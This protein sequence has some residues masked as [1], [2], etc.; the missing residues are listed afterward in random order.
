[1]YITA[2]R[3]LLFAIS[4]IGFVTYIHRKTNIQVEFI[5]I[6][7]I[8]AHTVLL[9]FA[10]ILN[11]LPLMTNILFLLGIFLFIREIYIGHKQKDIFT[12]ISNFITPGMII[13]IIIGIFFA[14]MLEGQRLVY[15]DDFSHWGL[16][17][18]NLLMEDRL[19]NFTNVRIMHNSYP[20]GSALFIY[21]FCKIVGA[22]EGLALIGQMI[23]SMS[24][25][26][27][28]FSF[29]S[30]TFG[31]V[32]KLNKK[33][34]LNVLLTIF[35]V[36]ISLKLLTG[37]YALHSLL[38][39]E[40]VTIISVSLFS[41]IYYYFNSPEA[42]YI[43]VLFLASFLTI[44]KSVGM[45]F[46]IFAL[47]IYGVSL[48]QKKKQM[49]YSW[50]EFIKKKFPLLVPMFSPFIIYYLWTRHIA[51]VYPNNVLGKHTVSIAN[52]INTFNEKSESEIKQITSNFFNAL[53]DGEASQIILLILFLI[54]ILAVYYVINKKWNKRL[55]IVTVLALSIFVLYSLGLWGIYL[56]SMSTEEALRL[57]SYDRYMLSIVNYLIGIIGVA[58]IY[59]LNR[60]D[61]NN[62]ALVFTS[63][64]LLYFGNLTLGEENRE[65]TLV[66]FQPRS[67]SNIKPS[68]SEIESSFTHL[69]PNPM[70]SKSL[71]ENSLIY[72]PNGN[73]TDSETLYSVYRLYSDDIKFTQ[74]I[75][76]ANIIWDYETISITKV[77]QEIQNLFKIYSNISPEIGTYKIDQENQKILE[78]I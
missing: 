60:S 77:N 31:K 59:T 14:F 34:L 54:V 67:V 3:I 24:G 63:L 56:V 74:N 50:S 19:P 58:L 18:K 36:F 78:K 5:P 7:S 76:D 47:I 53:F 37:P 30:F 51:I 72:F 21:Y 66:I 16:I 61:T 17:V 62:V 13:F 10:G 12:K 27:S 22:T 70:I 8:A 40:L 4:M 9:F 49:K 29:S 44:I 68:L 26:L 25:L 15:R 73:Y 20:P 2:I 65:D 33:F 1:M 52:Y 45:V 43:P 57:A 42:I 71:S 35:T 41:L 48:I 6:I 23:M 75:N 28:L 38:V 69:T 39:D 55:A 64:L 32:K 11:I 46:A